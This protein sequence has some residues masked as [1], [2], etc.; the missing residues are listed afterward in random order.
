MTY[1]HNTRVQFLHKYIIVI[2]KSSN[3]FSVV[4]AVDGEGGI[5]K[6]GSIPWHIPTDLKHFQSLTTSG[7]VNVVIMGRKTWDSLPRKPLPKRINFII[8]T[9]MEPQHNT[10]EPFC[11]FS[12]LQ[13]ALNKTQEMSSNTNVYVIGGQNLYKE[14][15]ENPLCK[16]VHVTQVNEKFKCDTFFPLDALHNRFILE[17]EG[18]IN[19]HNGIEYL[20]RRYIKFDKNTT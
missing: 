17:Y 4:V 2:L 9:T 13:D 5:G 19:L 20:F 18:S 7:D 6:N 16:M 15:L 12:T 14:A 3:M 1:K 10:N 8:S 11:V